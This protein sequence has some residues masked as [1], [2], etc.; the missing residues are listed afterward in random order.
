MIASAFTVP[1]QP[2]LA[3]LTLQWPSPLMLVLA[4]TLIVAWRFGRTTAQALSAATFLLTALHALVWWT[5]G[6]ANS[7][8]ALCS[9]LGLGLILPLVVRSRRFYSLAAGAAALLAMLA[10]GCATILDGQQALA[11]QLL[12]AL[13][14]AILVV[15]LWSGIFSDWR[16]KRPLI[17]ADQ[18]NFLPR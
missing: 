13:A 18:P 7:L 4:G 16:R 8:H 3:L 11:A 9:M 17:R 5:Y 2:I 12:A 14:N 6:S 10:L 15:A 1:H